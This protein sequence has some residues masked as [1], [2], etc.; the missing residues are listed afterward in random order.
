MVD[1]CVR[2][3]HEFETVRV[4]RE[5]RAIALAHGPIAL[6][7]A[8]VDEEAGRFSFEQETRASDLARSSTECQLHDRFRPVYSIPRLAP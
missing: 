2:E 5:G 3:D 1:V 4:E 8:A 6:K 7:H